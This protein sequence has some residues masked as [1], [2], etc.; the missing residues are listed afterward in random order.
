MTDLPADI[1]SNNVTVFGWRRS[2]LAWRL[3]VPLPLALLA[4][5]AL[6]WLLIPRMISRNV[7]N[8]AIIEGQQIAEQFQT[9][10]TYYTNYVVAKVVGRGSMQATSDHMTNPGAIPLPAT[11][12]LDLSDLLAKKNTTIKL[13]SDYPF[14]DRANRRL[15]A[16][17]RAALNF[18]TSNPKA[19]FSRAET[20]NNK[21]VVR[22][23][24][25]DVMTQACVRCHNTITGSPKTDWKIGDVRG[26]LEVD[27]AIDGKLA[28]GS[29]LSDYIILGIIAAG[30]VLLGILLLAARSVIKPTLE[31][32]RQTTKLATGNLRVTLPAVGR[33]DEI[34][35]MAR[36]VEVFRRHGLE[37]ER[38]RTEG[39]EREKQMAADRKADLQKLAD[40][41]Q[42][43]VGAIV[44]AVSS[45]ANQL[46]GA[47][48]RLTETAKVT[49]RRSESVATTCD[50]A[51]ASFR[52]VAGASEQMATSI[53]D[54][55]LQ[56]QE[57]KEIARRAVQQAG[58]TDSQITELSTA[59]E[60]IGD[61]VKL[62][63]AIAAQTNL[64]AL[65]ATIEAARAGESGRG[66]A[67]VAQ[68]V[69]ALASQTAK[70]AGAIAD[71]ITGMQTATVDSFVAIKEVGV[72]INRISEIA[73]AVTAAIE[74]QGTA[75]NEIARSV[76]QLAV[77]TTQVSTDIAEVSR[78]A[79]DTG[80]AAGQVLLSAKL[81]AKESVRLREELDEFLATVRAA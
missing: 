15:D 75:T 53:R 78:D 54:I 51:S 8:E 14:P 74:E 1:S 60:H 48:K 52:S 37:V 11:M 29:R 56:V 50:Q 36:S 71:K 76:Q 25:A 21:H 10:R 64:L 62:I 13:Y 9:F 46:E 19:T 17:Q 79:T 55:V 66:F 18:L 72:T 57:S 4:A 12:I 65:N 3:I 31:I 2:S 16:F 49:E 44:D 42:G 73:T 70:A 32:A 28:D 77:G 61:V 33:K 20:Q 67:I 30:V 43:T 26:V 23:A 63:G 45:T 39:A 6:T 80:S 22:T 47:A 58:V 68:E 5:I 35:D 24:I 40:Q 7:V 38:L 81:L 27:S 59:A 41:F 34:G 69:K